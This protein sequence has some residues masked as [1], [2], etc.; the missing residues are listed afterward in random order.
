MNKLKYTF[1]IAIVLL[2]VPLYAQEWR[3]GVGTGRGVNDDRSYCVD[4]ATNG[5]TVS[6]HT[7]AG[8]VQTRS[9]NGRVNAQRFDFRQMVTGQNLTAATAASVNLKP[10]P[11]GL[12]GTNTLHYLW[13]DSG[14]TDE[15]VLITGGSCT[16]GAATGTVTFTPAGS[17]TAPWSLQSATAGVQEAFYALPVGFGSF[18][19]GVIYLPRGTYTTRATTTI[20]S[21]GIVL[22][23]DGAHTTAVVCAAN[24]DC[25]R[26]YS[27]PFSTRQGAGVRGIRFIGTAGANASGIHA[28]DIT[29]FSVRD[30]VV[31]SFS[32]LNS[33]CLWLDNLTNWTERVD[34]RAVHLDTCTKGLKFSRTAPGLT[35]FAYPR[36]HDLRLNINGTDT[37]ISSENDAFLYGGQIFVMA[38]EGSGNG[39]V[40]SLANSTTWHD[41]TVHISAEDSGGGSVG[42]SVAAGATWR[43]SGVLRLPD[44]TTNSIL[45]SFTM[46][47]GQMVSVADTIPLEVPRTLRATSMG[48][49]LLPITAGGGFKFGHGL[50]LFFDGTNWRAEGDGA[51][52][53]GA[54]ILISHID[55]TLRFVTVP[56]TGTTDQTITD[57]NLDANNI[58]M[59]ID[60]NGIAPTALAI[61]GGTRIVK[62]L[63]AAANLDFTALAANTCET[64]TV[65][66]TGAADGDTC[67]MG[68]PNA[69]ADVDGAAEKTL[70]F[71][72]V[73]G[74]NT[75]S[76]RRCNV[77]AGAT[78]NPAVASVRVDVW[79]H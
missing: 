57:A 4:D 33:A 1:A 34:I 17:H 69:L 30:T 31:E 72:W 3:P 60:A 16:S 29:G 28:G 7:Q 48:G 54:A 68:I 52:N 63:S 78:A 77:T 10:C 67:S 27:S 43:N 75:A 38:N 9:I 61:G 55:G 32:G 49:Y 8:D 51:H 64:F 23:G 50:N 58:R 24:A 53:G 66:V 5:R 74:A 40:L 14:G 36:I 42:I 47:V 19:D 65:T 15:A 76:V 62:H 70:F 37:G 39:T 46:N 2:T 73:S 20:T 13:V 71:C 45:G 26:W 18:R 25:L 59:T 44:G 6:C 12:N 56:R 21:P 41:N 79:Q 22:E 35:S 11:E